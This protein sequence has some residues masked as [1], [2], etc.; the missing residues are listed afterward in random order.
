M[1][2]HVATIRMG[3]IHQ[4]CTMQKYLAHAVQIKEV[5]NLPQR[6]TII[7]L[8]PGRYMIPMNQLH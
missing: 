8:P 7:L 5:W 4:S 3:L 6:L 2:S 1:L